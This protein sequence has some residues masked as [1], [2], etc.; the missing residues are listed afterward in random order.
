M[1]VF[2][3]LEPPPNLSGH[4][5]HPAAI[6]LDHQVGDRPVL[7]VTDVHQAGQHV[8]PVTGVQ[9]RAFAS[10]TGPAKLLF[11]GSIQVNHAPPLLQTPARVRILRGT[12]TGGQDYAWELGQLIEDTPLTPAEAGLA[13]ALEDERDIDPAALLDDIVAVDEVDAQVPGKPAAYRR[14]AGA[15]GANQE[16]AAYGGGFRGWHGP[17][18][19]YSGGGAVQPSGVT[20][21]KGLTTPGGVALMLARS[22]ASPGSRKPWARENSVP[23][24][25]TALAS[26]RTSS[27]RL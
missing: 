22:A 1:P 13:L 14:L 20:G 9:Q 11:Y 18:L 26:M 5:R 19:T 15:H 25:T 27:Q 21:P 17:E 7:R 4:R 23:L 2:S 3:L 6:G 24:A 8:P 10:T 12:A 16:N